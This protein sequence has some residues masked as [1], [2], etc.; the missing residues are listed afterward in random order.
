MKYILAVASIVLFATVPVEAQALNAKAKAELTKLCKVM[1]CRAPAIQ[2]YIDKEHVYKETKTDAFPVLLNDVV[3]VYPNE[4]IYIEAALE[5]GNLKL[6]RA[7]PKVTSP[8]RTLV[9]KFKQEPQAKDMIL[10]ILNPFPSDIKFAMGMML[11]EGGDIQAT[12]SCPIRAGLRLWE[13]WPHPIYQLV[14]T[15]G[16]VLAKSDSR[17]CE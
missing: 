1:L 15:N 9:F 5:N 14:L 11:P 13:H 4:E 10:E 16:R 17:V 7:V 8:K 3:S 2:L 12:S 6:V